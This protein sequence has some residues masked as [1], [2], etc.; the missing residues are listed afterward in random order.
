MRYRSVVRARSGPLA[1]VALVGAHTCVL[2]FDLPDDP[3]VRAGVL[4]FAVARTACDTDA[5]EWLK[6]PCKFRLFPYAGYRVAGTDSNVAPIQQ[7]HWIDERLAPGQP[8]RYTVWLVRGTPS[9][10]SLHDPVT[11]E[12]VAASTEHGARG[13]YVNHGVTATPGYR[14]AFDNGRPSDQP[15]ALVA[16]AE[17]YLSRG[18][19][20]ALLAFIDDTRAG[21]ALDVA[22][23]EFQHE[24]VVQALAAAIARGVA[25]RLLTHAA[26]GDR[27]SAENAHFI[28]ALA[29]LAADYPGRLQARERRHPARLSHNKLLVRT[30]GGAPD[31][32]WTGSTNFTESG[33]FL[34][35]NVGLVI[36]DASVAGAYAAYVALLWEDEPDVRSLRAAVAALDA[37]PR[38]RAA[39]RLFFSPVGGDAL[40]QVAGDLIRGARD[41]V[42]LSS[43]FGIEMG[44]PLAGALAD[45][46]A[47]ER[48]ALV[49]GLLNA[50]ARG[51]L[52]ALDGDA[53]R[54]RE[55]VVPAW[56]ERLN[57]AVYDARPGSHLKIHIKA[58]VT[59]PWGPRPR[60]LLGSANFS[61]ESVNDNDENALL[62]EGDRWLAAVL[63]TEFL[64]VLDHYRFRNRIQAIAERYDGQTPAPAPTLGGA[65]DDWLIAPEDVPAEAPSG[66]APPLL[67]AV[68]ANV[69]LMEDDTWQ[70]PYVDRADPR[71]QARAV[72][73]PGV[74]AR[75]RG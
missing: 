7:F 33:F 37:V 39:S 51:K 49:Y 52:E 60:V 35:T 9:A 18:L 42:L 45:L 1:V 25:V 63:A 47:R 23:Y 56:I 69:W 44:G 65:D 53:A 46:R 70:R 32:V 20:E 3:A 15:P 6:N 10:P 58:L 17:A 14:A 55:F 4:G 36:H 71:C 34:Q 21:D 16:A 73:A 59:D 62:I 38:S 72:F 5:S 66:D 54:T 64:R 40:L 61:D 75:R 28:A 48:P 41:V 26:P 43:P 30:R 29:A 31:T 22:I 12:L 50:T 67:G 57:D 19:H 11:L 27:T 8:Y 68:A 74:R 13:V 24:S 2:G